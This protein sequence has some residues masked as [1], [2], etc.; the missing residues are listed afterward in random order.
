MHQASPPPTHPEQRRRY[1]C[2]V[3]DDP[4]MREALRLMLELGGY[5]VE[6]AAEG[7]Q[8]LA[9]LR[10]QPEC[11]LIL[12]DLM[13]P[14]MNGWQFRKA[15]QEVPELAAIPVLVLSAMRDVSRHAEEVGAVACFSKPI[16][17]DRLMAEI[18]RHCPPP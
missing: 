16:D 9:L 11:C 17:T 14:G 5:R 1:L 3:D 18:A 13:M 8:A 10:R 4:D 7:Q 12:L 2:V 6:E 15:Q